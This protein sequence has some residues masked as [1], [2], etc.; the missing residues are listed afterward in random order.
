MRFPT[1][2]YVLPA[3]A[4][5]SLRIRI[6][7]IDQSLCTSLEYSMTVKLLTE[8][9]LEFFSLKRGCT[10]SSESIYVKMPH[11]WKSHVVAQMS[12]GPGCHKLITTHNVLVNKTTS[13]IIGLDHKAL[14]ITLGSF[15]VCQVKTHVQTACQYQWLQTDMLICIIW[16]MGHCLATHPTGCDLC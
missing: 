10:G 16:L 15:N 14:Q 1:K 2:W 7:C 3:N 6:V 8:H 9:H 13:E 12:Y 5:T 11:C 4:K